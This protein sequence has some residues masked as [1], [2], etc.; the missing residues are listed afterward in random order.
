M[1]SKKFRLRTKD[2]K[3]LVHKR[4]YFTSGFFWF[5]YIAQYDNL[6][7][8]QTSCHISLKLSKRAT[9]RNIIKR[10]V[11]NRLLDQ[12]FPSLIYWKKHYKIFI[13][14][15]KSKIDDFKK[16]IENL[17]QKDIVAFVYKCI[18]KSISDLGNH[19]SK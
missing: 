2:V 13:M 5:F 15:Q 11:Y 8:N 10:A 1:L 4:N 16:Q 17:K 12:N 6:K 18:W 9:D 19:L 14:L 7:F 3:F